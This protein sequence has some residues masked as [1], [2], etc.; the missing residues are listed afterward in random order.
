MLGFS[1]DF[2]TEDNSEYALSLCILR[3]EIS[4]GC[5]ENII[6]NLPDLEFNIEDFKE[7]YHMRR[8]EETSFRDLKYALCLKAFHS[9]RFEY[10]VQEIWA[11]AIMYNF[12]SE[13]AMSV[14]ISEKNTKYI[15]QINYSAAIKTC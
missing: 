8:T 10:I 1:L 6:T 15:Y 13:I 12:Y 3:I 7:L 4:E 14:E 11:R 2:L 5:Y 9:K